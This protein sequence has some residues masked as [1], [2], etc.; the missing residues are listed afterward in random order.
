MT[1]A[2]QNFAIYIASIWNGEFSHCYRTSDRREWATWRNHP[3]YSGRGDWNCKSLAQAA[4]RYSWTDLHGGFTMLSERL[5]KEISENNGAATRASCLEIFRWGGVGRG[6]K[7]P[8]MVWLNSVSNGDLPALLSLAVDNLRNDHS[9]LSVFANGKLRMNSAMTK[10]YAALCPAELV[11]YDGRVGAALGLIA[12]DFLHTN[13]NFKTIPR[14][15]R[16]AWGTAKTAR[17]VRN[18]SD[19]TYKFPRLFGAGKDLFHAD[20]MQRASRILRGTV[21]ALKRTGV[22]IQIQSL[23]RA[24]FMIGYDLSQRQALSKSN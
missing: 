8:S 13:G 23:E 22:Q 3:D 16:F 2:E 15:L 17:L 14:E 11:M 19:D 24:L 20:C 10:V 21:D 6:P 18:P 5:R 4:D 12:R 1:E 7:N 9:D